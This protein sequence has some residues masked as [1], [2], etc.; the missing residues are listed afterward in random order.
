MNSYV[1]A[2]NNPVIYKDPRGLYVKNCGTRPILVKPGL[3]FLGPIG[4]LPPGYQ[5]D[6][7]PD[8][9]YLLPDGPWYKVYGYDWTQEND[10]EFT[11]GNCLVCRGGPCEYLYPIFVPEPSQLDDSWDVPPS[12]TNL[13]NLRP[14]QCK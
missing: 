13:G 2:A 5:W 14:A 12:P 6:G 1:Y 7:P 11:K 4:I 10:I 3:A 9:M 8:G